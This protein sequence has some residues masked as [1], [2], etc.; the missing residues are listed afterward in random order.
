M[1]I[2]QQQRRIKVPSKLHTQYHLV[3]SQSVL[4][5]NGMRI[6]SRHFRW[7]VVTDESYAHYLWLLI[8]VWET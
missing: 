4:R 7:H 3:F 1:Q 8:N 5:V 6:C 2:P